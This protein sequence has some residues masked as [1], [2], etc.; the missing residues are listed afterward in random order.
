MTYSET[1]TDVELVS[2]LVVSGAHC[3]ACI[4]AKAA[5]PVHRVTAAFRR[6]EQEWQEPLI[7]TGR[8]LACR[9]TTTV[10]SLRLP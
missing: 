8:C 10:Y 1:V 3:V 7:D 2:A 5:I 9:V 4:A 6:I